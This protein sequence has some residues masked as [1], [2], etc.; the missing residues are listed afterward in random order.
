MR[1]HSLIVSICFAVFTTAA[2]LGHEDTLIKLRG[3]TLEGLPDKY[4]PADFNLKAKTLRIKN[5]EMRFSRFL[6]AFLEY[7]PPFDLVISA[8][9]YHQELSSLPPYIL[10]HVKPRNRD[11]SYELLFNLDTLEL[12]DATVTL[13]L[14]KSSTRDVSISV[15]DEVK[16]EIRKSIHEIE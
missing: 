7:D 3:T 2:V 5:H 14:S 12:I 16:K 10:F 15:P 8:S 11:F 13:Q 9:W 6:S 4:S 1:I